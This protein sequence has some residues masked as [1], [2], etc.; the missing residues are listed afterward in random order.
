MPI[1]DRDFQYIRTLVRSR[2]GVVLTEDKTY[3]VE[4]RL[5][6]LVKE[7]GV[8]SLE[9]LLVK[10]QSESFSTLHQHVIEAMMTTETLFFRDI[11]PFEALKEF[12]L[13]ELIEKRQSQRNLNIWSAACSSGQEPYSIAMLIREKFP[14]LAS[15]K[16]SLIASDISSKM[17]DLARTGCYNQH[18]ISRGLPVELVD[19]YF[20]RLGTEW[21]IDRQIRHMVEFHQFNILETWPLLP[22]MDIIFLRNVLIYFDVS[23]KKEILAKVRQL[24]RPDGYLF[25]GGG[26]TTINLDD[27]FEP[28]KLNKAIGYRLRKI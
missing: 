3:L 18:Q 25:L 27:G 20:H 26:E 7:A 22:A 23:T 19:K 4:S 8:S 21:Q 13:P 6:F 28:V 16:I 2:T 11:E 1:K 24:L 14:Q 10:L 15:W 17:L 9:K 5:A 12:L